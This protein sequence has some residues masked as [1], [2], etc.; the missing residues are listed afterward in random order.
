MSTELITA[1]NHLI[2]CCP[3]PFLPSVFPSI[4]VFRWWQL[5]VEGKIQEH[6]LLPHHQPT[7][8]KPHT[9]QPSPQIL[10]IKIFLLRKK[11]FGK[12]SGSS[13]LLNMS[14]LF[15]LLGPTINFSVL[16]TLTFCFIWFHCALGTWNQFNNNFTIETS[17]C[18]LSLLTS[19]LGEINH[20]ALLPIYN[21][22]I[23]V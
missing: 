4:R 12:N 5:Q 20:N 23:S 6:P 2:L 11:K 14:H 3:L 8:R 13:E 7:R 15:S 18:M 9:L 10:P 21:P 17:L 16:H 19:I 22:L 1:S